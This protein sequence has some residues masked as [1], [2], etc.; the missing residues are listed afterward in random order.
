MDCFKAVLNAS[1]VH[2]EMMAHVLGIAVGGTFEVHRNLLG[3]NQWLA[4]K[5]PN[6]D[7]PGFH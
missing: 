4:M 2:L 7:I 1:E 5:A 3:G 6:S